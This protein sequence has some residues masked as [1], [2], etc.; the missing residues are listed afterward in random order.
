MSSHRLKICAYLSVGGQFVE[1]SFVEPDVL[2]YDQTLS[3]FATVL[4]TDVVSA[5]EE[6]SKRI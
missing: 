4:R 3:F 2:E 6:K 5:L 1:Q